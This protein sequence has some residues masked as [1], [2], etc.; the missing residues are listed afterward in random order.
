M[1]EGRTDR[2]YWTGGDPMQ[3]LLQDIRYAVRL[4][5]KKPGF[6]AV[7]VITLALGIGAN[8]AIFSVVQAVLLNPLP[9]PEADRIMTL[10]LSAPAKKMSTVNLTPGLF[11]T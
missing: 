7:V 1:S 11:A 2:S 5:A 8:T 10:S 9:L 6:S 4:M 3:T